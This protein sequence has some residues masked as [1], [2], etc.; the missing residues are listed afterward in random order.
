MRKSLIIFC[1]LI[2]GICPAAADGLAPEVKLYMAEIF[3]DHDRLV[4]EFDYYSSKFP[5]QSAYFVGLF[6]AK[7]CNSPP[8]SKKLESVSG[9]DAFVKTIDGQKIFIVMGAIS[10]MDYPTPEQKDGFCKSAKR[11]L[12]VGETYAA[13][14]M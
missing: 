6:A 13:G 5:V 12:D 10:S 1:L 8:P 7:P 2:F 14:Q 4:A 9:I 3:A 11:L